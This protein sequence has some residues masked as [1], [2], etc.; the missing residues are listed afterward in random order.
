MVVFQ[1]FLIFNFFYFIEPIWFSSLAVTSF[2]FQ[3][4]HNEQELLPASAYHFKIVLFKTN[5]CFNGCYKSKF[6]FWF[7]LVALN[8]FLAD[9]I[10]FFAE[11]E[12][13]NVIK[14]NY[15]Y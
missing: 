4:L 9:K 2:C 3:Q 5:S 11:A 10:S 8:V 13:E 1:L 6:C 14:D 15:R 12:L 7:T